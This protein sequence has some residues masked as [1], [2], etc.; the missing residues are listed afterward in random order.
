MI[1]TQAGFQPGHGVVVTEAEVGPPGPDEVLI[2]PEFS[3]LSAG[4]EL[5]SL[6]GIR[7][8][9]ENGRPPLQ[10]GYSQ[11][12]TVLA[13]GERVDRL[14]AGDRVV[15]IGA[16]AYHASRTLVARNLVVRRPDGLDAAEAA[17]MAMCC[18][19]LEAVHKS[20]V[21]IGQSVII[22]GAGM[23]G[24]VAARLYRIAG[25]R[26]AIMDSEPYRLSLVPDGIATFGTDDHGWS[27]L[28]DW[29]GE[30]GIEHAC[31]CFGGDATDTVERLKPIMAT[32]PDGVP[33]G[34]LV[35]PGGARLSLFMASNLGNLEFLSSAKAGPGYRDPSYESGSDY[36]AVYVGSPVRRNVET[37]LELMALPAGDPRRLELSGLITHRFPITE[38]PE[39]YR[40][41]EESPDRAMGV[42]FSYPDP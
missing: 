37:L 1:M 7:A 42:V 36:P 15:A 17:S 26:V 39:A 23:M 33:H 11:A 30:Y 9:A 20:A 5:V 6:R 18:F 35:F 4:T 25:A 2:A 19:A 38:A 3:Y 34:R 29:A 16:G 31:F 22:F 27:G 28:A 13:V 24:Q 10:P 41:V 40:L 21:R 8:A 12:G 32:A 14:A